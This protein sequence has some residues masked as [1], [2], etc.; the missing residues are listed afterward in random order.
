MEEKL[1]FVHWW[2]AMEEK[3]VDFFRVLY[4]WPLKTL[5]LDAKMVVIAGKSKEDIEQETD[6]RIS[7]R[8]Y[9]WHPEKHI[10][11]SDLVIHRGG[12]FLLW[13]LASMG[14]P[15][16]CIPS[17]FGDFGFQNLTRA[18]N[19]EK[20]GTTVVMMDEE[21]TK[22][23]LASKIEEI[24]TSKEIWEK[25]SQAGLDSCKGRGDQVATEN[26]ALES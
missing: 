15:S 21:L 20:Q 5:K 11:A 1:I 7:V 23:E 22:E 8:E 19:M 18:K 6:R 26:C 13:E 3:D 17:L 24:L 14:I 25:M 4:K 9:L 16:I 12:Y 10:A 2:E